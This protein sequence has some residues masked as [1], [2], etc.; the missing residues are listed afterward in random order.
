[1]EGD[2]KKSRNGVNNKEYQRNEGSNEEEQEWKEQ[3]E[4]AGMEG[5]VRKSRNGRNSEEEQEWREQ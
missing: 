1:M 3:L 2:L 5:A 4:R